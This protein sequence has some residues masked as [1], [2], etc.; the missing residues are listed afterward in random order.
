MTPIA[1]NRQ[2]SSFWIASGRRATSRRQ[3]LLSPPDTQSFTIPATLGTS[4]FL[5]W[6]DSRSEFVNPERHS[7]TSGLK[8][9]TSLRKT[10]ALQS[11]GLGVQPIWE[12]S[13][14]FQPLGGS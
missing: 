14:D 1:T 10:G 2:P 3:R 4:R 5:T 12:T 8:F 9:V 11:R 6:Q 13:P 7:Q